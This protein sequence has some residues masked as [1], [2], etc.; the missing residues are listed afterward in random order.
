MTETVSRESG[1]TL[2]D[3]YR[4]GAR[5]VLLTGVQAVARL[6]VEQHARDARA[7]L[8]T[9]A[10]VS[11]YPGCPLAGLDKTLAGI[12]ALRDEHDVRLSPRSTRN[13]ARPR[14]GA[15]S[16]RCPGSAHA[17]RRRRR[18]VRQGPRRRPQRRRLP[19][20]Q[21]LRRPPA[22]RRAGAGRRRPG[23]QVLDRAVRQ[24]AHPR[25]AGHAGALPAQRRG[26][27]LLRPAR[28]GAVPRLRLLGRA[29]GHRRRRRRPVHRRRGLRLAFGPVPAVEW[30]GRPWSYRQRCSPRRRQR[31]RRGGPGRTALGDGRGLRRRQP[32]R[33]D[34]G[35]SAVRPA[36]DRRA[37]RAVRRRPAGAARPRD[38]RRGLHRA[39]IRLLRIGMPYAARRRRRPHLR[40]RPRRDPGRRGEDARSSSRRSATLLYGTAR[41]AAG[42]GQARPRTAAARPGRRRAAGRPAAGPAARVPRR[43]GAGGTACPRRGARWSSRPPRCSGR[44]TSAAAAR[45]TARPCCPRARSAAAASAATDGDDDPAGGRPGH[46][47]EPDGRRG[48]AVDRPGPVHRRRPHLPERR[49]RHLLPLRPARACRPASPPA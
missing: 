9:A 33:R 19:A 14:S 45:T 4:A 42:A 30:Q 2:A 3:R 11:G 37:R 39:G 46:R 35:R 16:S 5:P 8:R 26:A 25:R 13:S 23:R 7:G 22:G 41:R 15:A 20:R 44:R 29:E 1:Y 38:G 17:R 48:R 21:P 49:R 34:R 24:R 6:L 10:L 43:P 27:H 31:A 40:Q 28:R 32:A 36:R 18:L 12:P 47:R